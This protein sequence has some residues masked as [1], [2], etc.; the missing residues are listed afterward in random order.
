MDR[1]E[2]AEDFTY[3][4]HNSFHGKSQIYVGFERSI[5][6]FKE[7]LF[8]SEVS[9]VGVQCMGGGG[10]TTLALTL[11]NDSQFKGL[12]DGRTR[13]FFYRRRCT[14]TA[15]AAPFEVQEECDGLPLALK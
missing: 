13:N 4:Y 15:A 12:M 14:Y 8:D 9:V 10:K 2:M 11:C 5:Q 1:T 3:S 7:L 6:D